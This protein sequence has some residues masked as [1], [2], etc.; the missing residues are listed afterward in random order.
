MYDSKL[1]L[2]GGPLDHRP[3]GWSKITSHM[4]SI[5]T[6]KFCKFGRSKLRHLDQGAF[7][8]WRVCYQQGLPHL[9]LLTNFRPGHY[10]LNISF[11]IIIIHY[12]LFIA[13][14]YF[15]KLTRCQFNHRPKALKPYPTCCPRS[16][17]PAPSVS[18]QQGSTWSLPD[19]LIHF[20]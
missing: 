5:W 12:T 4:W 1:C 10:F 13:R 16:I 3:N 7:L 9:V 6:V 20:P 19:S 17:K 18:P 14:F 2:T 15:G 11:T 8:R